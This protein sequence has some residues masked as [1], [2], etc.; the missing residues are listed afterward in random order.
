MHGHH[1]SVLRGVQDS[2]CT[3]ILWLLQH[4]SPLASS[5]SPTPCPV[6]LLMPRPFPPTMFM[7]PTQA[8]KETRALLVVALAKE[9]AAK[10]GRLAVVERMAAQ[11]RGTGRGYYASSRGGWEAEGAAHRLDGSRQ[12]ASCRYGVSAVFISAAVVRR[13]LSCH[14]DSL[15]Q[16]FWR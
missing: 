1:R 12:P 4:G 9:A 7:T 15:Q 5:H 6:L 11:V 14:Y 13:G 2:Q 8:V 16:L 3:C 10:A